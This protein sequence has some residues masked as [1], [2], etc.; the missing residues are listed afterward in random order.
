[1]N[2]VFIVF[3]SLRADC[4]E[5][6]PE[7]KKLSKSSISYSNVITQSNWTK[8]SVSSI[9]TS[10]VP[11]AH[12]I[13]YH[14]DLFTERQF[15]CDDLKKDPDI[16]TVGISNNPWI[17]TEYGFSSCF[18]EFIDVHY[19][20]TCPID[21]TKHGDYRIFDKLKEKLS[22]KIDN[23]F[24]YV[25]LMGT[26]F[27]FLHEKY[28]DSAEVS[29]KNLNTFLRW[30][31]RNEN[32]EDTIVFVGSDHGESNGE[33][34]FRF[35]SYCTNDVETF[36]PFF[37]FCNVDWDKNPVTI[38]HPY[39]TIDIGHTICCIFGIEIDKISEHSPTFNML[40][41]FS[42]SS[43]ECSIP[44]LDR[45][46]IC[47]CFS[48]GK[49]RADCGRKIA[50]YDG[51][52]TKFTYRQTGEQVNLVSIESQITK[53]SIPATPKREQHGRSLLEFYESLGSEF[54]PFQISS[55]SN[56]LKGQLR[57]LGY[58]T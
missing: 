13:Y 11:A 45:I 51:N 4:V 40:D 5:K 29:G 1:M 26:H 23:T 54:V 37:V 2:V 27:P 31:S 24:I 46:R 57:T 36:V 21:S 32:K 33:G 25:H 47:D 8:T 19:D 10:M 17:S 7:W 44:S 14:E 39:C 56:D 42:D 34:G 43:D 6:S 16:H 18:N 22:Q 28:W 35:H 30:F 3:D 55:M 41:V 49:D 58:L 38:D 53:K 52:E 15:W 48:D 20:Y 9:M 12:N 50:I